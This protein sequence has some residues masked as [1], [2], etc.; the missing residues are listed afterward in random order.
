MEQEL[1]QKYIAGEATEAEKQQVTG[2]LHADAQHMREYMALRKLYDISLW[3]ETGQTA[4]STTKIEKSE[5]AGEQRNSIESVKPVR[6]LWIREVL[7]VAAIVA[8]VLTGTYFWN[9]NKQVRLPDALQTIHVPAGQRAE[10][11]LVDGTRV[12]L[13]AQTTFTFP[14]GFTS[15]T[16]QVKLDGEGYFQVAKDATKPFIVETDKYNIRVLGTEFDVKSYS[17][18]ATFE[19]SLLEGSVE[20]FSPVTGGSVILE[21]NTQVVLV[22]GELKKTAIG[23]SDP[24]QWREGVISF[25]DESVKEMFEKLELYYGVKIKVSNT[26]ILNNRF[27]GKFRT[28]DG[29]EHVLKVLQLNMKFVYTKDN[30]SN[31][32][33]IG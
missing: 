8:I 28:R 18:E 9:Q 4:R 2:W 5:E 15:E 24:F 33:T 11:L 22:D 3:Q 31:V 26:D 25:W 32:I 21:P 16:R 29:I 14:A 27:T 20:V 6:R 1:L 12:W 17:A 19:T 10:L 30:E 13:N 23:E 7:K